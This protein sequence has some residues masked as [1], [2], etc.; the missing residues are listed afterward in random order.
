MKMLFEL[1]TDGGCWPNPGSG[2]WAF[3]IHNLYTGEI[4]K[5]KGYEAHTT[6]NRMELT[7]VVNGLTE[8]PPQ[9]DVVLYTDSEYVVK[10][11]TQWMD[12][13]K[14]RAWYG[15][16]NLDLWKKIDLLAEDLNLKAEWVRGHDGHP[17]NEECDQMCWATYRSKNAPI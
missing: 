2:A 4:L 10:G 9:S 7:A 5:E 16:M 11:I 6:N 12:K 17:E 3:I 14:D 15:V 1:F 8:L 13:W